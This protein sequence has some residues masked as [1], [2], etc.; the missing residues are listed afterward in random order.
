MSDIA[1]PPAPEIPID[2]AAPAH[3]I[4]GVVGRLARASAI[5]GIASF[6]IRA[7][8]FLLIPLYTR[9]LSPADY[10]VIYLA[11]TVA[12]FLLLF[13]N[14][15]MDT[16]T[17]RLYFQYE[18]NPAELSSYLGTIVRFALATM[19]TLL[20]MAYVIGPPAQRLIGGHLEVPFFPFIA[21]A[22]ATATLSQIVN[23]RLAIY[24]AARQPKLYG[25]FSVGLLALTSIAA[26]YRVVFQ[27]RGAVGMLSGK[28]VAAVA[29]AAIAAWTMR[30]Y[31]RAPFRWRFV[32]ETLAFSLPVVPHQMMAWGL[33]LA[34]RFILEHYRNVG[35]VGIYSLAY[36]LGMAMFMVTQALSQAWVP[37]FFELAGKD[38]ESH[39][40]LGRICSGLIILLVAIAS[41]GTLLSPVFVHFALDPRY[42]A[43]DKIVPLIVVG[44]LF[45]SLFS[46]F[47]ISIMQSK[48]TGYIFAAS[49]VAFAANLVLNFIMI[50]RWGM[51]GAA[52]ATTLA[53]GI[54]AL[55]A[56]YFAQRLFHLAYNP[57]EI[58][59]AAGV[60]AGALWIT[61][62]PLAAGLRV[63]VLIGG[64]LIS[65][66]L[67]AAIGRRD[68]RL[69]YNRLRRR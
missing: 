58:I 5:Y 41:L 56:Y 36:T 13:G 66:G 48:R 39:R 22:L 23:H 62:L 2:P 45:H 49:S 1:P 16:A 18:K 17:Q 69:A 14:L 27:G 25:L 29:V 30:A 15:A 31:M 64:T 7:A 20:T 34:D 57:A 8:N 19:A 12:V 38:E 67:L 11:E 53:Y 10:G 33:I 51:Y 40:I 32:R 35:E 54:E 28:L 65:W 9:Y 68:L 21:I 37:L 3:T 44:Y 6:T 26:V 42:R 63:W 47:H 50:P 4:G 46:L 55:I 43:A 61:Q 24:Q 59:A 52:W 60:C